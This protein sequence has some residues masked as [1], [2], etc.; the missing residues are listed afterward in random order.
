[1]RALCG[2]CIWSGGSAAVCLN[3]ARE[4][5]HD[6]VARYQAKLHQIKSLYR[7][8]W[9]RQD[10]LELFRFINWVLEL[11]KSLVE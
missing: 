11:G 4:T 3:H 10:V 9:Q 5:Q 6:T 2:Q 8:G 1:M 7:R